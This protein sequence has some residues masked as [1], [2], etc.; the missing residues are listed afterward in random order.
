MAITGTAPVQLVVGEAYNYE[1]E[2]D[3]TTSSFVN[4][5][6]ITSKDLGFCHELVQN[7]DEPTRWSYLFEGTETEKFKPIFTTYSITI[8][9]T[10]PELEPQILVEQNFKVV[11]NNNPKTC[12]V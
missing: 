5:V 4:A 9:S 11:A 7:V 2:F 6:F 10:L 3:E 1:L 8:H 12:G